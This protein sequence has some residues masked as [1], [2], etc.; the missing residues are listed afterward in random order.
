MKINN[1]I[2]VSRYLKITAT[3]DSKH[4][5][6]WAIIGQASDEMSQTAY[7][8]LSSMAMSNYT[9]I[10]ACGD[11]IFY[12]GSVKRELTHIEAT[13]HNTSVTSSNPSIEFD[14]GMIL[15]AAEAAT[16]FGSVL[17]GFVGSLD[18]SS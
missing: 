2:Q 9:S 17:I 6:D 4:S 8:M 10:K 14:E 11:Q 12:L 7:Q 16:G 18:F 5:D 3:L 1:M 13:F 15:L